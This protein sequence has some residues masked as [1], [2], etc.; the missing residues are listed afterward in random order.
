[1]PDR[2]LEIAGI[3]LKSPRRVL[4]E[5]IETAAPALSPAELP[6]AAESPAEAQ[7][8]QAAAEEVR[9]EPA[10]R[11]PPEGRGIFIVH[12]RD[13]AAGHA[14]RL[15]ESLR[16][17]LGDQVFADVADIE[18]GADL[19]AT[20]RSAIRES[21]AVVALIGP[22]WLASRQSERRR[23]IDSGGDF[24]R[25]ELPGVPPRSFRCSSAAPLC[26]AP[27]SFPAIWRDWPA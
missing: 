25:I 26:P 24:V 8:A 11:T 3:R 16:A 21:A 17:R 18:A 10:V 27:T 20:I 19:L 15:R 4:A 12:R 6:A 14:V 1:M 23:R 7:E 5:S 2:E 22:R 9:V 13:D